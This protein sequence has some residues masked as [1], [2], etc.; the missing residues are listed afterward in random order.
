MSKTKNIRVPS[1]THPSRLHEEEEFFSAHGTPVSRPQSIRTS[2]QNFAGSYSRA[3]I[4]YVADG[5][6]L[7]APAE[8]EED[9]EQLFKTMTS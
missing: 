7:H 2:I 8:E 1:N 3:S 6:S 9:E 5:I 4:L